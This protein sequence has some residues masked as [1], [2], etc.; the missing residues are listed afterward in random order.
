MLFQLRQEVP[1]NTQ[2]DNP[3][4]VEMPIS[5]GTVKSVLIRWRWGSGNLCGCRILYAGFQIWPLSLGAW[6]VSNVQDVSFEENMAIAGVPHVFQIEAYNQDDTFPHTL[7]VAISIVREHLP[8][9]LEELLVFLETG[10]NV[11]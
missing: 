7:E 5:E 9:K 8:A 4:R 10:E 3:L 6:F 2:E 1:A 11:T